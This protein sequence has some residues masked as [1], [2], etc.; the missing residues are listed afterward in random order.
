MPAPESSSSGGG[1]E[2]GS[3]VRT[4]KDR[5]LL[6]MANAKSDSDQH[7]AS[8]VYLFDGERFNLV[9]SLPTTGEAR[10]SFILQLQRSHLWL[11]MHDVIHVRQCASA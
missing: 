5:V 9:Q 7:V 10:V 8:H 2:G 6:L 4:S 11:C 1:K 3:L